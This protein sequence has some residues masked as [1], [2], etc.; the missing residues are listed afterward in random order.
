MSKKLIPKYQRGKKSGYNPVVKWNGTNG[1]Y[2]SN[3]VGYYIDE[4]GKQQS[5]KRTDY[6]QVRKKLREEA[7][8]RYN[9][10]W[11]GIYDALYGDRG[12]NEEEWG[13]TD[14]AIIDG[15]NE[16]RHSK[17]YMDKE[18]DRVSRQTDQTIKNL[19]DYIDSH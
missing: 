3:T 9:E 2:D 19:Q 6:V 1:Y 12:F 10:K 4:N 17:P 18:W 5:I 11:F 14:K 15:V 16:L 13:V 8:K 7:R